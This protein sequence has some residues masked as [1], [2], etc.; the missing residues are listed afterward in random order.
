MA[1]AALVSDPPASFRLGLKPP[2]TNGEL[3]RV[4]AAS[5]LLTHTTRERML[6]L[7]AFLHILAV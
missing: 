1:E 6:P 2:R 5:T 3:V 7:G 4:T